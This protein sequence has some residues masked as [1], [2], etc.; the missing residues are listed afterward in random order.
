MQFKLEKFVYILSVHLKVAET[1]LLA[2]KFKEHFFLL[3]DI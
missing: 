3:F 1:I 2:I